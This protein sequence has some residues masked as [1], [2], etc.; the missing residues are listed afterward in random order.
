MIDLLFPATSA[1]GTVTAD[2]PQRKWGELDIKSTAA[3]GRP[4]DAA[5]QHKDR[6]IA[7][8]FENVQEVLYKWPS[9][10][11]PKDPK[12]KEIGSSHSLPSVNAISEQN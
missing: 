4:L 1:D 8:G 9:N 2:S 7:A 12:L 5:F 3:L 6:M 10:R 11:W